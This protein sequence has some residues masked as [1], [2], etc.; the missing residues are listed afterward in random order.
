MR[1]KFMGSVPGRVL[2]N[3]Q[4]PRSFWLHSVAIK[5]TQPLTDEYQGISL[6]IKCSWHVQLTFPLS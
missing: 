2:G 5:S 1:W 6:G 4:G 3:F